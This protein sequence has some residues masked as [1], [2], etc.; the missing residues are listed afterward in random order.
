MALPYYVVP[1]YWLEGYA[2]GDAISASCQI[3]TAATVDADAIRAARNAK[4]TASAALTTA[5]SA[6]RVRLGSG[7]ASPSL[8]VAIEAL[9]ARQASATTEAEIGRAHV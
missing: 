5:P 8:S 4:A 9:R 2:V 1:E 3:D 7:A 6:L